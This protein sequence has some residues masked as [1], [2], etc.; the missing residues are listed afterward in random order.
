MYRHLLQG[1]RVTMTACPASTGLHDLKA[2][3]S[4]FAWQLPAAFPAVGCALYDHLGG[5][6]FD[7]V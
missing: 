2:K 4:A 1:R 5:G 7:S 3:V 6:S